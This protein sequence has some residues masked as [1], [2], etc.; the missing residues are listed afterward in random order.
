MKTFSLNKIIAIFAL[1]FLIGGG[2]TLARNGQPQTLPITNYSPNNSKFFADFSID[3]TTQKLQVIVD[4]TKCNSLSE[5][6][7]DS[8]SRPDCIFDLCPQTTSDVDWNSPTPVVHVYCDGTQL[9][10]HGLGFA[11]D[12]PAQQ[13]SLGSSYDKTNITIEI[14]KENG[15]T[16]NGNST[17][18]TATFLAA[19][20]NNSNL[21]FASQ[22]GKGRMAGTYKSVKVVSKAVITNTSL[23][24]GSI[25]STVLENHTGDGTKFT[26]ET[27]IDWTNQK[28]VAE[29]DISTC[30]TGTEDLFSIGDDATSWNAVNIHMYLNSATL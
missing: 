20:F 9:K 30:G 23:P 27:A 16:V 7:G 13:F 18:L 6:S 3:W 14:D 22:E 4:V 12:N 19:L 5:E 15:L 26:R 21:T 29:I 2:K 28:V 10:L 8:E 17:R 25:V 11:S 24:A 1:L